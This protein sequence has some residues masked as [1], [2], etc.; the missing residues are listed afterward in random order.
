MGEIYRYLHLPWNGVIA[1]NMGP[2]VID[3]NYA[4]TRF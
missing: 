1:G 3:S 4:C 2:R